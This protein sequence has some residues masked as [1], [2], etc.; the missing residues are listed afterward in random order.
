MAQNL[1]NFDNALKD[2]YGPAIEEQLSL[3]NVL[4]DWIDEND[5]SDWTGRQVVYPIHVS[6]NQGVGAIG[7]GEMLPTAG[8]QGY[9]K[10]VIPEKYNYGRIELTAQV[11]KASQKD[12]GA[13]TR[14]MDAELKGIVKDLA[15]DRERQFFGD[16]NGV[17][18]L[19]NAA[20]NLSATAGMT[21]DSPFGVSPTT[22]GARFLNPNMG[23]VVIGASTTTVSGT[24]TVSSVNADG[25]VVTTG[26][27][28]NITFPDNGRLVRYIQGDVTGATNNFGKEVTGLLGIIDDGTYKNTLHNINRTTYPVFKSTVITSVGALTLDVIQRAIDS[29]DQLGGGNFGANGVFFCHYSVRREY[30]KLLQ[31]DR[32]Y[33]G[34]D[35]RTPDGGTK[36]A[37]LKN[38]GEI[39]YGDRPWKVAKHCPYG[40]LFGMLKGTVTR[41]IHVR[42][43]WADEDGAVL[44]NVSNYDKWEAFYRIYDELHS[45]RP[46]EAFRLDGITATVSIAH[47]Y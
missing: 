19:V 17:L 5:S 32:R 7:E 11:I 45:D 40:T 26:G 34:G 1:T 30:L 38:G 44:R 35:L 20:Q 4:T 33:T 6:R 41:Y 22:D 29:S 28:Q 14:A 39:T 36:Q 15:N 25:T 9:A 43:E 23:I 47:I 37:A 3:V 10:V 2:V 13:F 18:A 27:T 12:K 46:N 21:I 31:A 16:G 42:G 8:N 24:F